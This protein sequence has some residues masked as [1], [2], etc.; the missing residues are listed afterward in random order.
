MYQS[1]SQPSYSGAAWGTNDPYYANYQIASGA[2]PQYYSSQYQTAA[3]V[4]QYDYS[5]YAYQTAAPVAAVPQDYSYGNYD[6]PYEII[7]ESQLGQPIDFKDSSSEISLRQEPIL[8]PKSNTIESLYKKSYVVSKSETDRIKAYFE[9]NKEITL[10]EFIRFSGELAPQVGLEQIA[11]ESFDKI[12]LDNDGKLN[13]D[14][15]LVSYA[16]VRH[17]KYGGGASA[18]NIA[19]TSAYRYY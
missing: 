18:T 5:S 4:Q 14:D 19:A 9:K 6:A 12:D 8:V 1:Y 2:Q 15:F 7:D 13:F 10:Q 11:E 3:P 16:F 17:R